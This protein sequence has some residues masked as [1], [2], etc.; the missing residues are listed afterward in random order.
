MG[1]PQGGSEPAIQLPKGGGA[2][3]GMG[4]KFS[5]DLFT[6]TGNMSVPIAVPP[7]R[8]GMQPS[9]ALGYSTGQGNG[10]FGLGWALGIPGVSRQTAKGIP[11]YDDG[12]DVFVLSGAEDL[13]PVAGGPPGARQYRP[14]TEGLFAE[15][16]HFRD[17][18]NDFWRVRSNRP[19]NPV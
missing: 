5:P 1:N 17:A 16:L 7:G 4:E 13:V 6:G 8:N 18:A 2:V 11:V 14:R 9:I 3:G 10:P 15:I 19:L 12:K